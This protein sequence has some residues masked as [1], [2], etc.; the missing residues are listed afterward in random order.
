MCIA[1][2]ICG[3]GDHEG[4]VGVCPTRAAWSPLTGFA[5]LAPGA[6]LVAEEVDAGEIA[7]EELAEVEFA[8]PLASPDSVWL[9]S[10]NCSRLFTWTSW[11]MYSFGS[12]LAVGSWFCISVTSN[13]RKSL[14]EMVE[15]SALAELELALELLA[16]PEAAAWGR[17]EAGLRACSARSC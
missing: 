14:A 13:V 5:M 10:I 8:S 7:E 17:A 11:L 6:A 1:F 12:V 2:M 4:G 9:M 3:V 15:E 16:P